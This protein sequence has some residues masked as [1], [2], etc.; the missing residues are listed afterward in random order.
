MPG[1]KFWE[2]GEQKSPQFLIT[3][4]NTVFL[5]FLGPQGDE[6]GEDDK[7]ATPEVT[8]IGGRDEDNKTPVPTMADEGDVSMM[9]VDEEPPVQ[10][11]MLKTNTPED[12]ASREV[13]SSKTVAQE[14]TPEKFSSV[15]V[16]KAV[17][18]A[19]LSFEVSL[20]PEPLSPKL[21]PKTAFREV[22]FRGDL[23]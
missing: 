5:P 11:R 7:E 10:E 4:G 16:E 19:G 14:R 18:G 20:G 13:E 15:G 2:I 23:D 6:G 9:D 1:P 17:E 21:K 8:V 12:V 3:L 22:A